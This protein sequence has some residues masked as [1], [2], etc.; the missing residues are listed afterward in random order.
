MSQQHDDSPVV[1]QNSRIN[2]IL[3]TYG[4]LALKGRNLKDFKKRLRENINL[5]LAFAGPGWS[6]HWRH[7]RLFVEVPEDGQSRLAEVLQ[8]LEQVAGLARIQPAIWTA[9][10]EGPRREHLEAIQAQV[11]DLAGVSHQAG[12][13]F[14]VKVNRADKRF[15]IR[16]S[17][18]ERELGGQIIQ[19]TDWEKVSLNHADRSF[20]INLY[21]EGIYV[22]CERRPAM[23][24]L[25][26]GSGGRL[27]TMLSGGID[28]PVA[29]W[30][31]AKRGCP[32]D[33][34]HFTATHQQQHDL[35]QNKV[36]EMARHLSHFTVRS[37]LYLVP[38]THFDLAMLAAPSDYGVIMFRRFMA[39]VAEALCAETGA[40][41]LANGDSLGQVASQTLENMVSKSR[42]VTLPIL[43][44]LVGLD[45]QEIIDIARRIGTFDN[46]I[47]PYKDCCALIE[48]SPRTR[49]Q[50]HRLE[51]EESNAFPEYEQMIRDTLADARRV[52]FQCGEAVEIASPDPLLR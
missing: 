35:E 26:V 27:M 13:T 21:P 12:Q 37:R 2:R 8:T 4:E 42:A 34:I 10:P 6:A 18:L 23:G 50:H 49:S 24:G 52:D 40:L 15:A 22:F 16:S 46:A 17:E 33:F 1:P 47:R 7:K 11:L 43:R 48:Q 14:R 28:S 36:V 29:A 41:A 31:M 44:P 38:Y 30:M 39:R 5:H 19:Q 3:L 45:K 25:P 32:Q 9:T 51:G 20:H